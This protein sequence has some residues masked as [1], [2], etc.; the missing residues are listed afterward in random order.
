MINYKEEIAQTIFNQLGGKEFAVMTGLKTIKSLDS[1]SFRLGGA[2][3]KFK[4]GCSVKIEL[5]H[6]DLY[7]VKYYPAKRKKTSIQRTEGI[8]C[9]MLREAFT[10]LTGYDTYMPIILR[11]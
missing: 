10:R 8:Y 6:Q 9:N 11:K 7:D 2:T 1:N 5:T 4:G 3:F